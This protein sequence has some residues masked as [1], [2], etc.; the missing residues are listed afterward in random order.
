MVTKARRRESAID[1]HCHCG[2]SLLDGFGKPED[3]V[4]RAAELGWPAVC[5]TEHGN[6][7]SFPMMYKAAKAKG[8]KVIA[9]TEFYVVSDAWLGVQDK[10]ARDK[11]YHLTVL[12]I[13]KEGYHNLVAWNTFSHK[14]DKEHQNYY[15]KPRISLGAMLEIAPYPLHHNVVLSGCLGS[16]LLRFMLGDTNGNLWPGALAY[17]EMMRTAFPN[18]YLELQNHWIDKFAGQGYEHYDNLL[19]QEDKAQKLLVQLHELTGVPCVITNDSHMQRAGQR[20]AHLSMKVGSWKHHEGAMDHM[21]SSQVAQELANYS[22][23]GNFMRDMEAVA[24]GLP[25]SIRV[26]ALSNVIDIVRESNVIL[27]P[28]DS[29]SYSLPTSGYPDPISKIRKRSH[30]RLQQLVKKHGKAA[31]DRFNHEL[32]SMG[33]FAHYLLIMSDA[34]LYAKSQGIFTHTR[35]SAASS[36]LCYCLNIHDIDSIHYKLTF[37]RFYNPSRKKLPDIDVDIDP[38]RYDDFMRYVKEYMAEREG[39]GQIVQ[40]CNYGTFANRSAFRMVAE[41]QGVSKEVI[42]QASKLLPSMIDSGMVDEEEDAYELLREEYPDLYELTSEIFDSIKSVSQH[43]CAWLL[44]TKERPIEQWVPLCLIASSD[45]TVTQFNYKTL[46][47]YFGL[48]KGDFLRLKTL[49]VVRRTM[50]EAGL[51]SLDKET[52]PLDDAAT[53]KMIA[54][55]DTDGVHSMQGKTQRQGCLAVQPHNIFD[56]IAIQ[57]LYRPGTT[58]TGLDKVFCTRRRGEEKVKKLHPLVDPILAE[59]YNVPLYQEQALDIGYALGFTHVEAQQLLD[60]IKLAKGVGRG[61]AEAFEELWP[62]FKKRAQEAGVTGEIRDELWKLIEGFQGYSFNKAHATS[63][64][65]L[66]CQTAYLKKHY[67]LEF[68]SSLLDVYPDKI[69][70]IASARSQGF[71]FQTPDVNTSRFGFSRGTEDNTI[72]VGFSKIKHLGPTTVKELIKHQPFSSFDD[73]VSR[74][75]KSAVNKTRRE[76]LAA[77]GALDSLG[78]ESPD[79]FVWQRKE[80]GAIKR[81]VYRGKDCIEFH[82]LGF[83]LDRPEAFEDIRPLHTVRKQ[84]KSSEWQH[85]GL[86][87]G[88]ELTEGPVSVSKMFWIPPLPRDELWELKTSAWARVNVGLLS[89]VDENGIVFQIKASEDHPTRFPL[90]DFLSRKCR[91]SVICLDGAVRSPFLFDGPFTFQMFGVTGTWQSDPQLYMDV[92]NLDTRRAALIKL[93]KGN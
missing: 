29:F 11:S 40:I 46:D 68:F 32:E 14:R 3:T 34:I 41:A 59:T 71:L 9:G 79:E 28:L 25:D 64:A 84:N 19:E 73:L 74:C 15:H 8:L 54:E 56:L 75:S 4:E 80:K 1:L 7:M 17:V 92:D 65:V 72:L 61:A 18:F 57:A 27:D 31:V 24:D 26:S 48:V 55:G 50:I 45:T 36:I 69:R 33:D 6:M 16:E 39:E 78:L 53:Y 90:L 86:Q 5:L 89:A 42:D 12:G 51:N 52:L 76:V 10:I 88:P 82:L 22:Y 13:S 38:D 30:A 62:T 44:G 63:Y 66:A 81:T 67:P 49:S 60:A 23:F 83:T 37:E 21:S 70:Y 43:A 85:K 35:G 58:R 91:G 87:R 20:K 93:T 47:K 77:V 2:F